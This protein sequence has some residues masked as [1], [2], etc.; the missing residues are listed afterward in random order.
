[1][2]EK[3]HRIMIDFPMGM[4]YDNIANYGMRNRKTEF[5]QCFFRITL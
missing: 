1:M 4:V 5:S 2:K 3:I